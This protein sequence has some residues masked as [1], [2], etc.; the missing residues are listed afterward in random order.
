MSSENIQP[1]LDASGLSDVGLRR[2]NNEDAILCLPAEGVF[3]VADGMGGVDGGEVA[4]E[5][6]VDTF[7]QLAEDLGKTRA[8][9]A[10]RD[11][12]VSAVERAH[13]V[14][15]Y[16]G[17]KQDKRGMGSTV[18]A[19]VMDPSVPKKAVVVHM[20]DSRAYRLREGSLERLTIDHSLVADAGL[21][22]NPMMNRLLGNIVTRVVGAARGAGPDV[23]ETDIEPGDMILLCS[24]GLTTML[25]DEQIGELLNEPGTIDEHCE[26]LVAA[27][28]EAGGRD[29][30]SVVLIKAR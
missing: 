5:I 12:V 2:T 16:E 17:A 25:S 13:E 21:D 26:R 14:I 11:L 3:C 1:L 23:Q 9:S 20:G 29:N 7:R 27:A 15:Q 18:V 6:V 4:S 8:V 22:K 19:A 24:D 28:N 10:D 30:V